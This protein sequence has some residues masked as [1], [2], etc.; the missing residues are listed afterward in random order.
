MFYWDIESLLKFSGSR[1][2]M[3]E[4]VFLSVSRKRFI[5]YVDCNAVFTSSSL[6]ALRVIWNHVNRL[7][8][9]RKSLPTWYPSTNMTS[10]SPAP[11]KPGTDPE[12]TCHTQTAEGLSPVGFYWLIDRFVCQAEERQHHP[13]QQE[14]GEVQ[15]GRI[16]LEEKEGWKD[17]E[18][19][20][21]EAEGPGHGG[22]QHVH[23]HTWAQ[24]LPLQDAQ[25]HSTAEGILFVRLLWEEI[26]CICCPE[27]YLYE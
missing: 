11:S 12:H 22:L 26:R 23:T 16:L 27:H 13:V 17:D 9:C 7:C 6:W 18:R 19:R 20:P 25:C 5:L 24:L 15:K 3:T 4:N 2:D 14:E 8:F 1:N 21:H 10:G